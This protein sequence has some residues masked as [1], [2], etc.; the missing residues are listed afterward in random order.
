MKKMIYNP[1]RLFEPKKK[2]EYWS[3][4]T[5]EIGGNNLECE[6]E[7]QYKAKIK[8]QYFEM[9]NLELLDR[10]IKVTGV[11]KINE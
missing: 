3:T 7:K 9:Y 5:I 11:N 10:E 4:V 6:S 2:N 8:K 1:T